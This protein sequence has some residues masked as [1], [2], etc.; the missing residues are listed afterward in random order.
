[1][2]VTIDG[3]SCTGKSTIAIMLAKELDCYFLGSGSLYRL[4][5][6]YMMRNSD[7]NKEALSSFISS[8]SSRVEF[9]ISGSNMLVLLDGDDVTADLHHV[10]VGKHASQIAK[11]A[12]IRSL[13]YPVQRAFYQQPGLVAEGRDMG[14]V[15]FKD[16]DMKFFLTAPLEVRAMRRYN[17]LKQYSVSKTLQEVATELDKRDHQDSSREASP[18]LIPSGAV[19]FDTSAGDISYAVKCLKDRLLS[20]F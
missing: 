10:S 3:Q 4:V 6:R 20:K 16:A 11:D 8:L 17:Q 2:L 12:E 15:I 9:L 5:A 1:M 18:L 7:C 14:S 13:L 19:E